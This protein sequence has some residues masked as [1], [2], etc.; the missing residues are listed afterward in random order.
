MISIRDHQVTRQLEVILIESNSYIRPNIRTA[1]GAMKR[2]VKPIKLSLNAERIR[3]LSQDSLKE[4]PGGL[5]TYSLAACSK[6]N[7]APP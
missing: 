5:F 2:Q 7:G 3:E 4:V 1:V 6:G